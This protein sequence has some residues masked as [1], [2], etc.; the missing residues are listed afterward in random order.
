MSAEIARGSETGRRRRRVVITG[1][2]A[3]SPLGIGVRA[4]WEGALAGRSGIG[5]ITRMDVSEYSSRIGGEVPDFDYRPWIGRREAN[6]MDRFAHMAIAAAHEAMEDAGLAFR[7]LENGRRVPENF[8][9]IRCGCLVGSGIGGLGSFE[10]QHS[11]LLSKGPRRVS[12]FTIPK[13]MANSASGEISL[14]YGLKGPNASVVTA[15]ASAAHSAGEAALAVRG[16]KADM[17]VTGGSEAS[18]TPLGLAG[19]CALHALSTRN[20]EPERASRP[21]DRDR[22]GFVIAEGAGV[23]VLEE[24]AS[25]RARGARI[26]AEFLGYGASADAFHITQ[27]CPD[28]DGAARSMAAAIEDAGVAPE[29]IEYVNAHGTSTPYNDRIE[30]LAIKKVLGKHAYEIPVNSTKSI[31]GHSLG[32]SAGLELIVTALSLAEGRVHPTLNYENPDPDCD[33][34][35]VPKESREVKLRT[36]LSNSLGFGGHNASIVLGACTD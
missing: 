17:M 26:Y 15:C 7:G 22:D 20:D 2:G 35:Y 8:D 32:A 28:G 30:T 23:V 11:R 27:P 33:L 5:P 34:D 25:A 6:R 10:E 31:I 12:A 1:L 18:L 19:F 24:L 3:V 29:D 4:L 13:L 36:A 21:F 16:G 9:G 14:L